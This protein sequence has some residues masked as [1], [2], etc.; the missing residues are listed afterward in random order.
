MSQSV[1]GGDVLAAAARWGLNPAEILD[2]SANMNPFGPPPGA[3]AAPHAAGRPLPGGERPAS[4]GVAGMR[5]FL[6]RHGETAGNAEGRYIGWSDLPLSERGAAQ[7]EA[8]GRRLAAEPITVVFSSDLLRTSA[9]AAAI[10][11][12]HGLRHRTD[13]GL[14]ELRF[15][16][17][18]GRTYNEIA[19]QNRTALEAWITDPET[20]APPGGE[21]LAQL[22]RRVLLALPRQDGAV[23]VTHGGPIRALLSGWTGRPFWDF[24]VPTG[25]LTV[26]RFDPDPVIERL[27]DT[28]G[29]P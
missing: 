28:D 16:A 12:P 9:T 14:R 20:V 10:A 13:P 3:L 8:L 2:F 17:F 1:H 25:S 24:A 15:G 19:D 26:V 5:L 23:V 27:A 6:V 11:A 18:E 22:R 4:G 29:L 7:A 21:T